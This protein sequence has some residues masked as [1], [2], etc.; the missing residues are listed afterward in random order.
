MR[1]SSFQVSYVACGKDFGDFQIELFIEIDSFELT[2]ID[3]DW[4]REYQIQQ[5]GNDDDDI[6]F[7][8]RDMYL[9]D[10]DDMFEGSQ[11]SNFELVKNYVLS[12]SSLCFTQMRSFRMF[13][14]CCRDVFLMYFVSKLHTISSDVF[15]S[16]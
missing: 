3:S 4:T 7:V 16:S 14:T 8:Y 5:D 13:C 11:D 9:S 15:F 1:R 10:S 12:S 2:S 6:D